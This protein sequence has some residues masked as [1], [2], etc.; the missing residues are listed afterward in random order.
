MSNLAQIPKSSFEHTDHVENDCPCRIMRSVQE[1]VANI[2]ACYFQY[3]PHV[4]TLG[5]EQI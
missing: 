2:S 1:A 4:G 5:V 3:K